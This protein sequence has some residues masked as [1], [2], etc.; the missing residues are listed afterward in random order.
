MEWKVDIIEVW[1][2]IPEHD[3][4]EV[5]NRGR[6]RSCWNNYSNKNTK[7]HLL[8]F[9]ITKKGYHRVAIRKA[10]KPR[11]WFVHRLVMLSFV[12]PSELETNHKNGIKSDN[13]LENLEYVT[14]SENE[15]H[16]YKN[17]LKSKKRERHHGCK[18]TEKQA[19]DIK[20]IEVGKQ[21]DIA[22]KYGVTPSNIAAI[23]KNRSWVNL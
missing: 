20:Y 15:Y 21:K 3:G 14:R 8:S 19:Y 11:I 4:Y 2:N 1:K 6:V 13:R 10:K 7:P 17:N 9:I 22:A 23:Q 18:L 5:S 16:A 12:G